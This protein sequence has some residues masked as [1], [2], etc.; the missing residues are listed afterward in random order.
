MRASGILGVL[1]DLD[2]TLLDTAPDMHGALVRLMQEEGRDPLPYAL[3][4]D[5]V[6]HGSRRLV[7][8]GFP[9]ID[10]AGHESLK[11]R[12]LDLYA[13]HLC[14][15]TRLFPGMGESLDAMA[16]HGLRLGVVTNK[17]GWLTMPLLEALGLVQRFAT[18]VSGDTLPERK[19]SPAPMRHAAHQ[20]GG[21]PETFVYIGDAER[22][23]A[24]GR[25]AG[26]HTLIAGWG[27][28]DA[29]ENPQSWA[30][31]AA[32]REP[33]DFWPW[34]ERLSGRSRCRAS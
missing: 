20:A 16:A 5:H 9:D 7:Q 30:A 31:D 26:M 10:T 33:G 1:F 4:R 21:A 8:L 34:F 23:I 19:P 15:D 18:I 3:V 27:Y 25:A 22:D 32:L 28:I 24:A 11:Q 6:S 29:D 17:P 13:A 14:L 2:G 12:F